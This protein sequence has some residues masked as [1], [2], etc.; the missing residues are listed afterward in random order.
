MFRP[1]SHVVKD[2]STSNHPE[3]AFSGILFGLDFSVSRST[4]R[5]V[6][7]FIISS[8]PVLVQLGLLSPYSRTLVLIFYG[9]VQALQKAVNIIALLTG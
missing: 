5:N 9:T 8:F 1:A 4:N 3:R 7:S 2:L 6:H